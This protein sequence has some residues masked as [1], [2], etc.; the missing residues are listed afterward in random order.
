[1]TI[2]DAQRAAAYIR[3]HSFEPTIIARTGAAI[4]SYAV[5]FDVAFTIPAENPE[6]I[7]GPFETIE[8]A[9]HLLR[10]TET[11]VVLTLSAVR[12]SLGY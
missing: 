10:G 4:G 12:P 7:F 8:D 1:M 5:A 11:T 3:Q 9:P 6:P 2:S